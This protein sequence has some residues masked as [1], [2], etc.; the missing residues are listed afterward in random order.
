MSLFS[1]GM[2]YLNISATSLSIFLS[3]IIPKIQYK[4]VHVTM[5]PWSIH[6]LILFVFSGHRHGP[7]ISHQKGSGEKH[8]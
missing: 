2:E 3:Q 5:I 7:A 1:L 8:L 4:F 6:C